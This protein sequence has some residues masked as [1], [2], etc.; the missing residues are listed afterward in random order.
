MSNF[1]IVDERW[2]Q[3]LQKGVAAYTDALMEGVYDDDQEILDDT[4]S[5][6]PFCGCE[7]CFW[8]ETLTYLVPAIIEAYKA[9]QLV[10]DEDRGSET[11]S[12]A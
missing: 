2:A 9:G 8:R 5:G 10:I 6:Y 11:V 1:E 3:D 7:D 4:L 12:E